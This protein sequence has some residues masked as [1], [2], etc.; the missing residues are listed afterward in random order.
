MITEQYFYATLDMA[1]LLFGAFGLILLYIARDIERWP[2]GL[3]VAI[4]LSTT[5]CAVVDLLGYGAAQ[6]DMSHALTLALSLAE[7]LIASIPSAST[8]CGLGLSDIERQRSIPKTTLHHCN[9]RGRLR[10]VE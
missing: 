6:A 5:A 9:E 2:K 3:C 1:A 8:P 4:L 7:S 10:L